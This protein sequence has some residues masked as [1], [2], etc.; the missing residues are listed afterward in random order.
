MFEIITDSG[1]AGYLIIALGLFG[2]A[3]IVERVRVLYFESTLDTE[4][5]MTQVKS[6]LHADKIEEAIE[7]CEANKT[8]PTAHVI[9]RILERSDRDDSTMEQSA[10][11]GVSEVRPKLTKN[12]G[13]LMMI[14]NVSTLIGL[15]GTIYGLIQAFAAV[16]NADPATKQML[17]AQ[18]I[19]IAMYTTFLGLSVAIPTMIAYAFLHSKLNMHLNEMNEAVG[20]VMDIL[21]S[22]GMDPF[23]EETVFPDHIKV[24]DG[25]I[26]L[27]PPPAA[28]KRVS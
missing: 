10:D 18:G 16:S 13:Y 19:S 27:T 7:Y 24:A 21:K 8:S 28:K 25:A 22:R 23:G 20:K 3:L 11:I 9:K 17:L 12:L 6:L 5:F 15:L 4:A 2:L 14:S 26:K 1:F